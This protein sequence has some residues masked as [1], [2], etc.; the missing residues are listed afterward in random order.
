MGLNPSLTA[1]LLFSLKAFG[2][3]LR[4]LEREF[5]LFL[6]LGV[7][8]V[9]ALVL[10]TVAVIIHV[11]RST[12]RCAGVWLSVSS[13]GGLMA[14]NRSPGLFVAGRILRGG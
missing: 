12:R 11:A 5:L 13:A 10:W 8:P 3:S 14:L 1:V 7:R 2:M 6:V 9:A 4:E